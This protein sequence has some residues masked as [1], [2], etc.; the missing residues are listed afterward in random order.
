MKTSE[1]PQTN[2]HLLRHY[3][4][5]HPQEFKGLSQGK[6]AE[7]L[8]ISEGEWVDACVGFESK[9]LIDNP[10]KFIS[11]LPFLGEV[12]VVTSSKAVVHEKVGSYDHI[13]F[14]VSRDAITINNFG[15]DLQVTPS[16]WHRIYAVRGR[17]GRQIQHSLQ[18]FDQEGTALHKIF[19]MPQTRQKPWLSFVESRLHPDHTPF[20][21]QKIHKPSPRPSE[22]ISF[23][24]FRDHWDNMLDPREF[25]AL[26]QRY[27]LEAIDALR[28]AGGDRA[29]RVDH[30]QIDG[31]FKAAASQ[32]TPL[33]IQVANHGCI[34]THT[35]PIQNVVQHREWL[36]VFDEEFNLHVRHDLISEAWV[37]KIPTADGIVTALEIF[38][39]DGNK[40]LSISGA[41]TRGLREP[42]RWRDLVSTLPPHRATDLMVASWDFEPQLAM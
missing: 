38:G 2:R 20:K 26:L 12:K 34:Q 6:I 16:H 5:T 15:V 23:Q 32:Q 27:K 36:A 21:V 3:W 28:Y 22:P 40:I 39:T 19:M 35:G 8:G 33:H 10:A 24:G 37:V 1:F 29:N 4:K 7:K 30:T 25:S 17:N 31:L 41:K 42:H 14:N 11:M 18:I 13:K 9:R